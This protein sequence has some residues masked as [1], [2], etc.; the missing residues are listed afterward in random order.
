MVELEAELEERLERNKSPL[1]LE[2]KPTKRN[3]KWSEQELKN[4][5]NAY[6]LNSLE[7]E[8]EYPDYIRINN[9]NLSAAEVAQLIKLKFSL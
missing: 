2:H 5:M 3:I 9:T 7:G 6:R 1:R 4:S 8:I